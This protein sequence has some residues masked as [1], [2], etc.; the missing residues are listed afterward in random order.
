M[1]QFHV[2]ENSFLARI[3]AWK[4]RSTQVA[5]VIGKT[6]HLHNTSSEEFLNNKRWL[7]HELE[8]IRQYRQY[9]LARFIVSYL[10]ESARRGYYNNKYEIAARAAEKED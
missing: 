10:I 3:A 7:H 6:I 8:H 4:M 5:I 2:K 1:V 9:G